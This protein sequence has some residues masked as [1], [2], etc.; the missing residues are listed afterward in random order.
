MAS[1]SDPIHVSVHEAAEILGIGPWKMY[2][3]C[4][5]QADET[6][7]VG[8]R[9]LVVLESLHTYA[10]NLPTSYDEARVS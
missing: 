2:K 4:D 1:K 7:Y 10:A 6:R 9:R 5:E 8:R 3:L